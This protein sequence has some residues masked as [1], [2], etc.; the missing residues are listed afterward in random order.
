MVRAGR[1]AKDRNRRPA[2][3]RAVTIATNGIVAVS[4]YANEDLQLRLAADRKDRR[5]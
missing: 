3:V 2:V 1:P 5:Q 4:I